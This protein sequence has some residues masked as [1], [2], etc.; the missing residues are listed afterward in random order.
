MYRFRTLLT[1]LYY[2]SI[3][4][5]WPTGTAFKFLSQQEQYKVN[6]RIDKTLAGAE[7]G[8]LLPSGHVYFDCE[9]HIIQLSSQHP[10]QMATHFI[11]VRNKK[12]HVSER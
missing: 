2:T 5:V 1:S 3:S 7:T 10:H 11:H 12:L 8:A 9:V 6:E 4:L